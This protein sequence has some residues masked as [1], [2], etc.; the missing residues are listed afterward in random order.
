MHSIPVN[1]GERSHTIHIGR[2]ILSS[3]G[4]ACRAIEIP[5]SVVVVS[6][7]NVARLYLRSVVS[8]LKQAGYRVSTIVIPHGEQQKSMRRANAL[9]TRLIHLNIGKQSALFA[10]GGGVI[11][12]LTGLVASLYRR[13]V[14]FV[15][16]PTTLLSQ[17]DSSIGGKVAV[18]HPLGKNVIGTFFQPRL[19]FSDVALLSTLPKREVVSGVGEI[20]KY[21]IV[22]DAA[23]RDFLN[24]HLEDLLLLDQHCLE[25]TVIACASFKAALVSIDERETIG[26]GGRGILNVGHTVGQ[27]IEALSDFRLRHGESVLLGLRAECVMSRELGILP[28]VECSAMLALLDRIDYRLP[29]RRLRKKLKPPFRP[30]KLVRN[31]LDARFVLPAGFGKTVIRRDVPEELVRL[32]L[33]EILEM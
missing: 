29:F 22:G 24:S 17:A 11:G 3:V 15:Q 1:L 21:A 9:L 12:D 27:A 19:V 10:L 8:S 28:P 14:D 13:G 6:D 2:G 20:I 25:E 30:E 32:G 18:N 31:L 23:L 7:S 16:V 26:D 5:E 33:V 4:S